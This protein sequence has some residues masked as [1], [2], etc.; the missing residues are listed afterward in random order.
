MTRERARSMD[1]RAFGR[2]CTADA[3]RKLASAAHGFPGTRQDASVLI[4]KFEGLK[5][6]SVVGHSLVLGRA[7]HGRSAFAYVGVERWRAG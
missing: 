2:S 5:V 6:D 1:Q 7:C 3:A 4:L